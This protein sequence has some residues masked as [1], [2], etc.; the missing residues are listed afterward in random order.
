M[1]IHPARS[2]RSPSGVAVL[3]DSDLVPLVL[4]LWAL[5]LRTKASC[6]DFGESLGGSEPG[7][8]PSDQR[9][10]AFSAGRVWLK[11]RP[12]HAERLIG[13]LGTDRELRPALCEWGRDDSWICVRPVTPDLRGGPPRT[14]DTHLFF[15]REHLRRVVEILDRH[16]R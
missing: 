6:Q 16:Q 10:V 15:P 13:I 12:D 14:G 5:G 1:Q 7:L 3:I 4:R 11:M 2:L 8:P 9:W